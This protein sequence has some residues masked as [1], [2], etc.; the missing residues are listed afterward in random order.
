MQHRVF[1]PGLALLLAGSL[2]LTGCASQYGAQKT[3]VNYYPQCYQPVAQLRQDENSTGT[4]TA[5]GA[6]GGALLGA[7]IGGLA[8]GKV[9]GA[10]A[11]AAVG[12]VSG[13]VAGNIY[14]KSQAR[15]RDAAYLQAYSRQLGSEA[16]SMNRATAAAKVAAKCYDEQFQLAANQFKAGQITRLDF[17]DRYNEIRSGLEETSFILNSTA[18]TMA[19]KDSE[20]QRALAEQYTAAEPASAKRAST[21]KSGKR[22][23]GRPAPSQSNVTAQA[24][25]WKTSR[26]ELEST[27]QDVDS[28]LNAYQQT[29]DN[30]LI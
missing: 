7:L 19:Q 4:S 28:R 20:Y 15:D 5:V 27:R 21:A 13:A 1:L 10:V 6:A 18:T 17:Q 30:L 2:L 8:T 9:E 3:K 22:A 14:G 23:T 24:E 12:G 16:A 11:G 25:Q 29:V 26:E